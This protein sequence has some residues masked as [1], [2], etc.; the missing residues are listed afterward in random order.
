MS[1]DPSPAVSSSICS[2][3]TSPPEITNDL[4]QAQQSLKLAFKEL[5]KI[6]TAAATHRQ[7]H[8][9]QRAALAATAQDLSAESMIKRIIQAENTKSAYQILR[10]Y[11][12]PN[13]IGNIGEIE[14]SNL[15]G[16]TTTIEDP[17]EMFT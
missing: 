8:L 1:L 5:H 12:K 11:L 3:L 15:D 4:D 2:Q 17:A 7:Q 13:S 16:T 6:R 9:E 10:N 14:I